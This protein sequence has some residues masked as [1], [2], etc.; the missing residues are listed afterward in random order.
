MIETRL[1][2]GTLVMARP[3]GLADRSQLAE[4]Y[5]RLSPESRYQ[6]FWVR[7]GGVIGDKML[8][9]M[10][11]GS[12]EEHGLWAVLDP[13]R[14]FQGLG[15][16]SFWRSNEDGEDAEFSCT[17]LDE[18][19]RRGV[20]TLLLA[21][22]WLVAYRQGIRRFTGY[23]MP[24]NSSAIRWMRDTGAEA[25]WDGY[26][27]IFRWDL[28]NLDKLPASNAGIALAERLAELAEELLDGDSAS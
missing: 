14:D 10:L 23:T 15:A 1:A 3:L 28:A 4:G 12:V 20:G 25:E 24:E 6:R 2:D 26:K 18:D 8:D 16:A 5:R 17:V 13:A 22:L 7:T 27:V 9:R 11:A 19:Q 21:V